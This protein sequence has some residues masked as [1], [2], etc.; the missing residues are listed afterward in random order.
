MA[1]SIKHR[2]QRSRPGLTLPELLAAILLFGTV[3]A[4]LLPR[5]VP[6]G[7]P[8]QAGEL[9]QHWSHTWFY[10]GGDQ[11]EPE[12]AGRAFI[13]AQLYPELTPEGYV[14]V[15]QPFPGGPAHRAG[16][17]PF[18]VILRVNRVSTRRRGVE[19]VIDMITK[20]RPGTPVRLTIRRPGDANIL[21]L[22]IVRRSFLSVFLPGI[23]GD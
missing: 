15:R 20:G 10:G 23:V 16:L 21:E 17:R 8:Q 12:L 6:A 5:L 18:D 7:R 3:G 9:D 4:L 1:G 2:V 13:G 19:Q 22:R 14:R 11:F